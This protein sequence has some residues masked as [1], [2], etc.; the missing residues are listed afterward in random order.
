MRTTAA[1]HSGFGAGLKSSLV[2]ITLFAKIRRWR[3]L[4]AWAVTL[5]LLGMFLVW[6]VGGILMAPTNAPIG[7]LPAHLPVQ[8]VTFP[9]ASGATIHG[10]WVPGQ[11]G[12][13]VVVLMHGIHANRRAM[14]TRAMFL[15][16]AGYAVL[17]F[18]F[19]G[20]GESLGE[21]ITFGYLESRDVTA[22][23]QFVHA[24]CPGEKVALLGISLG[25][26]ATLLAEPP[27]PVQAMIL[28]SSY[29]TIYQA[30]ENRLVVRLGWLGKPITP[31][32]TCQ[33]KPRLGVSPEDLRPIE[34]ARKITVPKFFIAGTVDPNT[35]LPE[36][37]ALFDAAAEP[38]QFWAVEGAGHVDMHGF[39]KAE[40]ERRILEFLAGRM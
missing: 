14:I 5:L 20:H 34:H 32:L 13:G 22:A 7:A 2:E 12:R 1:N 25:A 28:E 27:L 15:T 10:W 33:L 4:I 9:S 11:P 8:D 24:K 30:T 40:Y 17:L 23:V 6:E 38:K 3:W 18:D 26:V 21:H 37:Q 31:L 35:T 36:S 19:Q 39:A 16:R 29:P